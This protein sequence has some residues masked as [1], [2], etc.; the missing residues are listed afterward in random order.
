MGEEVITFVRIPIRDIEHMVRSKHN[1]PNAM[2]DFRI[3][4]D[5]ILLYF[6][7]KDKTNLSEVPT[8][9]H[10][11]D[12][13]KK[14]RRRRSRHKR[15][16]MKTRG[17]DVVARLVNQRGQ[18]CTIYRPFVEALSQQLSTEEQKATVTRIL[19]S[20]RNRP[21]EISINYFLENTLEYLSTRKDAEKE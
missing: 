19:K 2:V 4:G 11:E 21:S 10:S 20:N 14:E 9:L 5:A 13:S 15:N 8:T 7:D 12:I 1:L 17:W 3:E 6:S 18:S 16:R